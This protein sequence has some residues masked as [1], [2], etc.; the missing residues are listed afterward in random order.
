[1]RIA[2]KGQLKAAQFPKAYSSSSSQSRRQQYYV[3]PARPRQ[4]D[5]HSGQAG[6]QRCAAAYLSCCTIVAAEHKELKSAR[7]AEGLHGQ[8]MDSAWTV[9][10]QGYLMVIY[11]EVRLGWALC[12]ASRAGAERYAMPVGGED[13]YALTLL[14]TKW[15]RR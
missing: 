14:L 8:C 1:M 6:R 9:H 3:G 12:A 7:T 2:H 13:V 10:G 15:R 11:C 4:T 5:P